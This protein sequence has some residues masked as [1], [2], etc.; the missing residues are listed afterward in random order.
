MMMIIKHHHN[1]GPAALPSDDVQREGEETSESDD[2]ADLWGALRIHPKPARTSSR[3][4]SLR[5]S[6]RRGIAEV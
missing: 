6:V 5:K 1:T 3:N 4:T 2:D